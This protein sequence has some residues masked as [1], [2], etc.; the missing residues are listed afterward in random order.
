[1]SGI[2]RSK[3]NHLEYPALEKMNQNGTM[4]TAA[5]ADIIKNQIPVPRVASDMP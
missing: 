3:D 2:K 4:R 1:M 5:P